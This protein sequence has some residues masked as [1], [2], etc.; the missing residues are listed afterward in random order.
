MYLEVLVIGQFRQSFLRSDRA[1][2][3]GDHTVII[4]LIPVCHLT[5]LDSKIKGDI[6]I[7]LICENK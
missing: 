5:E 3:G 1:F 4:H 2:H 6:P 7:F